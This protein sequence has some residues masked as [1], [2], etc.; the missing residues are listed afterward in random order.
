MTIFIYLIGIF[1][2]CLGIVVGCVITAPTIK[3]DEEYQNQ[4]W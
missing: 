4:R 2:L 3:E 1:L